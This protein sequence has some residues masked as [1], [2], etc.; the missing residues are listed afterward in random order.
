MALANY[1]LPLA[2]ALA[3]YCDVCNEIPWI[4]RRISFCIK[5]KGGICWNNETPF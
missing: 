1:L 2:L 4:S 3:F 5:Y